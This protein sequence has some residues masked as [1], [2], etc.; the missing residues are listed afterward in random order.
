M[1]WMHFQVCW[2]P[3]AC[4]AGG[5]VTPATGGEESEGAGDQVDSTDR[6]FSMRFVMPKAG[7]HLPDGLQACAGPAAP[8]LVSTSSVLRFTGTHSFC[9]ARRRQHIH[10]LISTKPAP[11]AL[12]PFD[13]SLSMYSAAS[14]LSFSISNTRLHSPC[15]LRR[16]P[17]PHTHSLTLAAAPTHLSPPIFLR[18]H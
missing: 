12:I 6:P 15:C 4:A 9:T 2:T 17:P 16:R 5:A 13:A 10:T 14:A 8:P 11:F 3:T 7:T 18:W 1:V